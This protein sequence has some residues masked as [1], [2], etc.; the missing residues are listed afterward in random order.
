MPRP[1][2]LDN[3][4]ALV[5]EACAG[6]SAA[7]ERHFIKRGGLPGP[8]PNY[9][10]ARDAASAL[11]AQGQAGRRYLDQLAGLDE[12]AAP[13]DSAREF[14]V[15]VG[16]MG[17]GLRAARSTGELGSCEPIESLQGYVE[18]SRRHV[19]DAV[20][21]ALAEVLL[22]REDAAV[23]AFSAW[24]D[25]YLQAEAVLRAMTLPEAERAVREAEGLIAR[26]DEAF[27]LLEKAP[28]AHER[29]HGYRALVRAMADVPPRIGKRF[30]AQVGAWLERRASTR[31]PELREAIEQATRKLRRQGG[32]AA[33]LGAVQRALDASAPP[34]RDP[35]SYVGPTRK[36]G[37]R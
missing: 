3:L 8:R 31:V 9:A 20:H 11:L 21:V 22:A 37:K 34:P 24:T 25:G 33:D 2:T 16:V 28:R 4:D 18:D 5:R 19:R 36:R 17:L 27:T 26:L 15:L 23:D 12:R 30:S 1:E 32:R 10:L 14:L 7:L 35:R 13:D 29:S 6:D